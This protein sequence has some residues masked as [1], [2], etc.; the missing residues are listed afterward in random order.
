[1]RVFFLFCCVLSCATFFIS[2]TSLKGVNSNTT[3][4]GLTASNTVVVLAQPYQHRR[5][6][7]PQGTYTPIFEDS[8]GIYYEAPGSIVVDYILGGVGRM[9]G[10]LYFRFSEPNKPYFYLTVEGGFGTNRT[11]EELP[12]DFRVSRKSR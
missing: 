5:Y 7:L 2:C 10:G 11:R 6:T 1:M 9:N 8:D 4:G 3:I 12:A